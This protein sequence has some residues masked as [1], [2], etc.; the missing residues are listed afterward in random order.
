MVAWNLPWPPVGS[1]FSTEPG[2]WNVPTR[3]TEFM[4]TVN[5]PAA[6]AAAFTVAGKVA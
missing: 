6:V 2:I 4:P 1:S 3:D 5:A